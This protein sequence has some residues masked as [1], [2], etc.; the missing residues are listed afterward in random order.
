MNEITL[1]NAEMPV[2]SGC[3]LLAASEPFFHADR[4]AGF[5]VMIYVLEGAIYVTEGELDY[6]VKRGELLF[7]KSGIRHYGRLEIP[8]GTRWFYVHFYFE[9]QPDCADFRNSD[10]QIMPYSPTRYSAPLPKLLTGLRGSETEERILSFW[11]RCSSE[12]SFRGWYVNLRLAELLGFIALRALRETED[13]AS[14]GL[15]G[16]IAQYLFDHLSEPFS[17]KRLERE[18]F[19]SYKRMAAVFKTETGMTMQRYHDRL[20]M[21]EACRLLRSTLI[22]VSEAAAALGYSDALYFSRRFREITGQ[23]PTQYRKNAAEMF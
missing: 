3:G 13:P 7:L 5:N 10:R 20:K 14:Q 4:I 19:L 11:E 1:N 12:D 8:K 6:A 2:V 21:E 23:S 17:S 16:R 15:S 18:F 9:E 22:P